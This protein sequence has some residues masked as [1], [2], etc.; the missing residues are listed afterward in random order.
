MCQFS[1][2]CSNLKDIGRQKP[3]ENGVCVYLSVAIIGLVSL[4]APETLSI[5]TYML[6]VLMY[7]FLVQAASSEFR[8]LQEWLGS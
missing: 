4:S 7:A 2:L 5:C 8:C 6:D 1:V 3:Q